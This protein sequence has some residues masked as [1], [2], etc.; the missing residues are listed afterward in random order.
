MKREK[1]LACPVAI[2]DLSPVRRAEEARRETEEH[3][4]QMI[5][6]LPQIPWIIDP[7]GRALDVSQRWLEIS[8]MKE[9]Q[10]R[11]LAGWTHCTRKTLQ[12]TWGTQCTSHSKAE[13]QSI[14]YIACVVQKPP[15]GGG[16][17]REGQLVLGRTARLSAGMAA[18]R[19]PSENPTSWREFLCFSR[20]SVR[21]EMKGS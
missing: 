17:V 18:L 6:L 10:W 13:T 5:E 11:V 1:W 2:A 19:T 12:P 16:G 4:R 3:F 15:H 20:P 9:N 14:S 21:L 8:G 7:E